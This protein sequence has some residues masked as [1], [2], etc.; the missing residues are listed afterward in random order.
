MKRVLDG[1]DNK[2]NNEGDLQFLEL[3]EKESENNIN[4]KIVENKNCESLNSTPSDDMIFDIN[5]NSFYMHR[6]RKRSESENKR[7]SDQN[8]LINSNQEL[9]QINHQG[10]EEDDQDEAMLKEAMAI[11][12]KEYKNSILKNK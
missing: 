7:N 11:S 8:N 4:S 6:K 12:L 2:I 1:E 10:D 3:L 9:L 5:S